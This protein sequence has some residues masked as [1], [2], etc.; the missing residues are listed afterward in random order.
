KA[1]P[2]A[3]V[4]EKLGRAGPASAKVKIISRDGGADSETADEDFGNKFFR[5]TARQGAVEGDNDH[6]IEAQPFQ[7]YCLA[8]SRCQAKNRIRPPK[9]IGRVW[10]E[11]QDGARSIESLGHATR[12]RDHHAMAAMNSVKITDCHHRPNETRRRGRRIV[13]DNKFFGCG[14][15]VQG[16]ENREESRGRAE[17][18]SPQ[19]QLHGSEVCVK[20]AMQ[21]PC[22]ANGE[23]L[24]TRRVRELRS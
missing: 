1:K 20:A 7:R 22:A 3:C 10:L 15:I 23:I 11:G 14:R 24:P 6:A 17:T 4:L 5:G 16:K 9:K 13:G 19:R 12:M 2:S 21:L 18:Q 8:V